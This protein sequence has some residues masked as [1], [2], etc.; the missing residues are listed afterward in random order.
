[1]R[2]SSVC[3]PHTDG[4]LAKIKYRFFTGEGEAKLF[5]ETRQEMMGSE[6]SHSVWLPDLQLTNLFRA[7]LQVTP[8]SSHIIGNMRFIRMSRKI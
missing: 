8:L 4:L 3:R 2:L 5:S 1:M 7:N 6:E